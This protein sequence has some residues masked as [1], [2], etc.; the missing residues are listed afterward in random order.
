MSQR[1]FRIKSKTAIIVFVV[2][3]LISG[4]FLGFSAGGFIVNF[5]E[6]GFSIISGVEKGI[7]SVTN[8]V[9]TFFTAIGDLADLRVEY[10]KLQA[11]LED[12]E[13]L[14]RNNADIKKENERLKEQLGFSIDY[15]Y[16]NYPAQIIS[17]DPNS[18]YSGITVNKGSKHNI[19]KGMPVLAIQN[20]DIGLVGRVVS[21]G[22][23]TSM[24]MP[25]YDSQCNVSAR[26]EKTRD[27]GIV[28]GNENSDDELTLKFIKKRVLEELSYG[29]VIVTSGE[30]ENYIKDIPI[31]TISNIKIL[32]YDTSLEIEITPIIDF[33]RLEHV[34]IIDSSEMQNND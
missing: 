12:Y 19:R 6:L 14:Q 4:L 13:Y 28:S 15:I 3:L 34:I 17:R 26:I 31:G 9:S 27:I 7:H 33:S 29:D 23:F 16:K 5:K 2:Y 20:G 24:I 21:V 25:I 18:L 22:L 32:D 10:E 8:G 1:R 30:N 11:K